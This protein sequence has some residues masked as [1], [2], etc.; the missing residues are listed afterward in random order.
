MCPGVIVVGPKPSL[1]CYLR[2]LDIFNIHLRSSAMSL[3][4]QQHIHVSV[5]VFR[6]DSR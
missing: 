4:E 3:V 1:I 2:H 5:G 6:P